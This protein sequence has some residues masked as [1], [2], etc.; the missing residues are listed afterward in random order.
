MGGKQN[1]GI[2]PGTIEIAMNGVRRTDTWLLSKSSQPC[3]KIY[4]SINYFRLLASQ[5]MSLAIRPRYL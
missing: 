1:S 5:G 3:G 2:E 4:V